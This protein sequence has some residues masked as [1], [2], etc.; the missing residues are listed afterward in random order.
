M[1]ERSQ[2]HPVVGEHD[3]AGAAAA[4]AAAQLGAAQPQ[5]V[6]EVRQEGRLR[7]GAG[8]LHLDAWR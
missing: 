1:N 7:A 2:D 5:G 8:V 3:G 4:L 6:P